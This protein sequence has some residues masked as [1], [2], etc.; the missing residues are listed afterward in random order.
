[1][2]LYRL[3]AQLRAELELLDN[4]I[5]VF[6]RLA[7]TNRTAWERPPLQVAAGTDEEPGRARPAGR[8][9]AAQKV[10]TAGA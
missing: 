5:R 8:R 9:V 10:I 1:M 6:E 4:A 3:I 2:D 7:S